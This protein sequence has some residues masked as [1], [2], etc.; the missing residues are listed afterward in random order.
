MLVDA[1]GHLSQRLGRGDVL[2][3]APGRSDG[4]SINPLLAI[5]GGLHAWDDARQLSH[6]LLANT[7]AVPQTAIDAFAPLMLDQLLCA[8]FEVRTLACLRRRLI[9]PARLVGKL[10]GRWAPPPQV[11]AA[12]AIWEMVRVARAQRAEPDQA[13]ADLAR[14]DQALAIFADAGFLSATSAHHL[15]WAEYASSATPR[16]WAKGRAR[17][18]RRLLPSAGLHAG[19]STRRSRGG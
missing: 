11:D 4:I 13:L 14:I 8:P 10:C 5:R 18:R 16:T 12:P 9:D 6:A 2:R 1:R 15:N 3:F 7:H 19:N 17:T